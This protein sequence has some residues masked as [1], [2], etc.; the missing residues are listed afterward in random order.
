MFWGGWF[1]FLRY[2][3]IDYKSLNIYVV[4]KQSKYDELR[5]YID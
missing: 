2:F 3:S 4:V 5:L 1:M